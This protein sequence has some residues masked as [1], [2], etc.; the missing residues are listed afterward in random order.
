MIVIDCL[1]S[2]I[3]SSNHAGEKS[4]K[5]VSDFLAAGQE[6]GLSS[7]TR[8]I[9]VNDVGDCQFCGLFSTKL[10]DLTEMI[11]QVFQGQTMIGCAEFQMECQKVHHLFRFLFFKDQVLELHEGNRSLSVS[12]MFGATRRMSTDS[13]PF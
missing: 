1:Q 12:L 2:M 13:Q 8:A 3:G 4:G 10:F 6:E 7:I 9:D 5:Q 11:V